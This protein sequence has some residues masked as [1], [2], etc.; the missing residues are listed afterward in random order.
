MPSDA[1]ILE[2]DILNVYSNFTYLNDT[3]N[4]NTANVQNHHVWKRQEVPE[5]V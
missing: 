2:W 4:L 3:S 5:T 1:Y